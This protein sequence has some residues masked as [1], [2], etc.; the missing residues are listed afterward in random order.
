MRPAPAVLTA[1]RWLLL[2]GLSLSGLYFLNDAFF[3]GW[4]AGGPP[5][6]HKLGWERRSLAS[7]LLSIAS[8]LAATGTF[9]ALGRVPHI[10]KVSWALILAAALALTPFAAREV[11]IDSC[12]DSGGR[13]SSAFLECEG[14]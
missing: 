3:S 7:L 8:F 13:W 14:K 5:G 6:P 10:G 12:L 2:I 11:L 1:I 9:R 4:V